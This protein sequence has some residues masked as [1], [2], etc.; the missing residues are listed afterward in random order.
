MSVAWPEYPAVS[1][2]PTDGHPEAIN[3]A[4]A[5]FLEELSTNEGWEDQGE[6]DG[7]QIYRKPDTEVISI[8]E[9]KRRVLTSDGAGPLWCSDRQGRVLDRDLYFGRDSNGLVFETE[10]FSSSSS[11][12]PL[13]FLC[14]FKGEAGNS[15]NI[16][17]DHARMYGEGIKA[18]VDAEAGAIEVKDDGEGSVEVKCTNAT[19][20]KGATVRISPK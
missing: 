19:G 4:H 10:E 3:K 16:T 2:Y 18:E 8:I 7:V 1:N 12:T 20:P 6:R 15:F 14:L 11:A 13:M 9:S 17:Y 5:L